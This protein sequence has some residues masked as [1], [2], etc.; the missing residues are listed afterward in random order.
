M[1]KLSPQGGLGLHGRLKEGL[2]LLENNEKNSPSLVQKLQDELSKPAN[3]GL[4]QASIEQSRFGKLNP[5]T[6]HD[7]GQF[8]AWH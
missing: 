7:S 1:K 2:K 3:D 6:R 4:R 8:F 5:Q